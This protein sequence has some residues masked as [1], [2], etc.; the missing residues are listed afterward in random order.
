MVQWR[1]MLVA[2]AVISL[3][4][5]ASNARAA[6]TELL[7]VTSSGSPVGSVGSADPGLQVSDDGRFV[8]FISN[9]PNV[10]PGIS[11]TIAQI[12]IHDRQTGANE[13][14]SADASGVPLPEGAS[15]VYFESYLRAMSADGRYVIMTPA[16][17]LSVKDRSTGELKRVDFDNTGDM[18][19][20]GPGSISADGQTVV[21]TKMSR[22][23]IGVDNAGR[24]K[25]S[26]WFD[27][28]LHKISTGEITAI[29]NDINPGKLNKFSQP[30]LSADGRYVSFTSGLQL[31]AEPFSGS[32]IYMYDTLAKTIE[33]IDTN[34]NGCVTSSVD[35]AI[36]CDFSDAPTISNDSRFVS[37]RTNKAGIDPSGYTITTPEFFIADRTAK[38]VARVDIPGL[39]F[40]LSG[41]TTSADPVISANGNYVVFKQYTERINEVGNG[42]EDIFVFERTTGNIVRLNRSTSGVA[43]NDPVYGFG[44]SADASIAAFSSTATNLVPAVTS[45]DGSV[46]Y[47]RNST[48]EGFPFTFTITK[49][50]FDASTKKVT[51]EATS[52]KGASAGMEVPYVG[53]MTWNNTK[54]VWTYTMDASVK[55][56]SVIV[57]NVEG[58]KTLP[59]V[60]TTTDKAPPVVI[61]SLP[62]ASA[63]GVLISSSVAVNFNEAIAKGSKFASISLKK[64][65]TAVKISSSISSGKLTIK[66]ASVLKNNTTYTVTIPAQAVKDAA[67]NLMS[68]PYSITFK[69]G[70]R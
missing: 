60:N 57:G 31:T 68:A 20:T 69:T 13:L 40:Q 15:G 56:A 17:K 39:E 25:Y 34:A 66:P 49:A 45:Y 26:V 48:G 9:T 62:S 27:M 22:I 37:Y 50:E 28:Y 24:P 43:S 53:A 4:V 1:K 8:L 35:G 65:N 46:I 52:T 67:G 38:N 3:M 32:G 42:V 58:Y 51:I 7:S 19:A 23:Q 33:R 29:T 14:V 54:G 44:I 64:G 30:S 12:F 55:P 41:G 6:T 36:A 5:A 11:P 21:F 63:T 16:G 59:V 10:V 47:T 61:S 18:F 70:S 2:T